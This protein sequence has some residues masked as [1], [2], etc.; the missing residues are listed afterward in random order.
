[1]CSLRMWFSIF[2][3]IS[4]TSKTERQTERE[5]GGGVGCGGGGGGEFIRNYSTTGKKEGD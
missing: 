4:M 3:T 5:E 2:S 1:M